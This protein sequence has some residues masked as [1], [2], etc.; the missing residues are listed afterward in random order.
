[1]SIT[2]A[3]NLTFQNRLK[4]LKEMMIA[5]E[6]EFIALLPGCNLSYLTGLFFDLMERP[7]VLLIPRSSDPVIVL[8]ELEAPKLEFAPFQIKAFPYGEDPSKWITTFRE[9]SKACSL[10][11][12]IIGVEPT[13]F[14]FLEQRLLKSAAPSSQVISGEPCLAQLRI[15]KDQDEIESIRKAVEISQLALEATIPFIKIGKTEQEISTELVIQL[16]RGGSDITLPFP[17]IVSSGPNSANPHAVPSDRKLES[18]DM[19]VI[20]WGGIYNGYTA[21]LSRTFAIGEVDPEFIEIHKITLEFECCRRS[22]C[23]SWNNRRNDRSSCQ[24]GHR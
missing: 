19:L 7:I 5:Q 6:M 24:T 2:K 16:F 3:T 4:H 10:D 18:G 20:D 23:G 12:R 13:G 1:M 22:R 11:G 8:P 21:D 14:R 9:A 15:Q 17:P